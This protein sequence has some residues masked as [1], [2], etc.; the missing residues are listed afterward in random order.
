MSVRRRWSIVWGA[1]IAYFIVAERIA[2]RGHHKDAP[3]SAHLRWWL[4][5]HKGCWWGRVAFAGFFCWLSRHLW[6]KG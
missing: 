5:V 1:W 2:L 3:L 4:G 6:H